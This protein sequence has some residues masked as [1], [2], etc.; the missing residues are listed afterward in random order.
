MIWFTLVWEMI[1][2]GD[3]TNVLSIDKSEINI[4]KN[5]V[6]TLSNLKQ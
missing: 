4:L 1:N 6:E 2:Y 3:N 5:T